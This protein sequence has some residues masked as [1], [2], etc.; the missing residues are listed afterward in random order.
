[1]RGAFKNNSEIVLPRTPPASLARQ[2]K[3]A[4]VP[5]RRAPA[6]NSSGAC[7]PASPRSSP[8]SSRRRSRRRSPRTLTSG[9]RPS[10]GSTAP[11]PDRTRCPTPIPG[12]SLSRSSS[13]SAR[14]LRIP[15][16]RISRRPS[17]PSWRCGAF[18]RL[19]R[20]TICSRGGVGGGTVAVCIRAPPPGA[21]AAGGQGAGSRPGEAR[22]LHGKRPPD[23]GALLANRLRISGISPE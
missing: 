4:E 1:M 2:W 16:P 3:R 23:D 15:C 18:Q 6:S 20:L 10:T 11:A 22:P 7:Y 13:K 5:P 21:Q 17:V 12:L 14:S 8:R 9:S 19:P